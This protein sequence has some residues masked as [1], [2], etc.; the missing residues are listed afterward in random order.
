MAQFVI[1]GRRRVSGTHR[2]PGNKNAALPMLAACVLTDKPVTIANLPLI[3][4]VRTTLDILSALGADV[5]LRGHTATVT[6]GCLRRRRVDRAL[7]ARA[8]SAILFAGPMAARHGRVTLHPPGG[9]VIGRRRLDTHFGALD[10]LGISVQGKQAYVFRSTGLHAAD[11]L[12]DEASVTA[13]ENTVMAAVLA[14]GRSTI[15]NAACEPHVQALC[16]MLNGMGADIAGIG[17]NL[18]TVTG[19]VALTGTHV[20]VPPD[21]VD[22]A[23]FAVAAAL[24][25]G[26]LTLEESPVADLT[27]TAKVF[28]RLGV[29]WQ[30]EG[31]TTLV[32]PATQPLRIRND[33]GAAIPKTEDGIWP[34][35]PS[36]L[37]SIAIVLA[38]QAS[39][40]MLFFEKLFESRLYFV[41][42]LIEMGARI[43]QCDPHRVIVTGPARLHGTTLSSPDIRAGVALLLAA[44]CAK[45]VSR[46]GN[47][48]IIDRGYET[49]DQELRR[50]GADIERVD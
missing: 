17:T 22:A 37:M 49:I 44:L 27:M 39:G 48:Q 45:G 2:V 43:V 33:F 35:F 28:H 26:R 34:A 25:G 16:H 29:G 15:F 41:D 30:P 50:L 3:D 6:C 9:D 32:V 40:A 5:S 21:Y 13:T 8:R 1:H 11:I 31:A 38:T 23:S 18:L 12:L 36:D 14:P 10:Q 20:H 42:R 47:A 19:V 4:D 46:I 24:T 7:C